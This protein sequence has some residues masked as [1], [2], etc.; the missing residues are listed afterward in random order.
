M[1]LVCSFDHMCLNHRPKECVWAESGSPFCSGCTLT[2][3]LFN[4]YSPSIQRRFIS[5]PSAIFSPS[6]SIKQVTAKASL[7]LKIF[8]RLDSSVSLTLRSEPQ[9]YSDNRS[10]SCTIYRRHYR[11]SCKDLDMKNNPKPVTKNK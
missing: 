1:I 10:Y 4:F 2:H 9:I 7:L 5:L 6:P 8:K 3:C 11:A